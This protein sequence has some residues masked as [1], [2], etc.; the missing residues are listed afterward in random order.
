VSRRWALT[1]LAAIA[2][3]AAVVVPALGGGHEAAR[4]PGVHETTASRL[5][6]LT[7]EVNT[8]KKRD[9]AQRRQQAALARRLK[10]LA[11][12][13][14]ATV[15]GPQGPPGPTGPSEG[16]QALQSG[17]M[18]LGGTEQPVVSLGL[19]SAGV[20][21]VHAEVTLTVS[22]DPPNLTYSATRRGGGVL[23]VVAGSTQVVEP[24]TLLLAP[25]ASLGGTL[26]STDQFSATRLIVVGGAT[27]VS[28]LAKAPAVSAGVTNFA[29]FGAV[30]AVRLGTGGGA[31][32]AG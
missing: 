3:T 19:P 4:Q 2:A 20:Y 14:T 8:L 25:T 7:R 26:A 30:T 11:R 15:V 1:G 24:V 21:E 22:G 23:R 18:N 28:L 13:R 29:S 6:K 31:I 9:A 27:T 12:R 32:S 5:A 16:Y 17:G 10:A